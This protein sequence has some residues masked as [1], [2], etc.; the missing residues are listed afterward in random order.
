MVIITT[1]P[2]TPYM[3]SL[4]CATRRWIILTNFRL[5][6]R[7]SDTSLAE[8]R[9][10][11]SV[12]RCC[13]KSS[14]ISTATISV[15]RAILRLS[16]RRSEPEAMR[17]VA[18]VNRDRCSFDTVSSPRKPAALPLELPSSKSLRS[19]ASFRF[20]V[21]P[22]TLS[23]Q[24]PTSILYCFTL[25]CIE[26]F[27]SPLMLRASMVNLPRTSSASSTSRCTAAAVPAHASESVAADEL[28]FFR[29]SILAFTS[30]IRVWYWSSYA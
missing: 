13:L 19:L 27:R 20:R 24:T 14:M 17:S 11:S 30:L 21:S 22:S 15:S 8:S 18:V 4:F 26:A 12:S 1:I 16:F 9:A 10:C 5:S 7:F 29:R 28:R 3:K 25:A 6:A 2:N 23:L